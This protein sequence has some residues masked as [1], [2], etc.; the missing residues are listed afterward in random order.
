VGNSGESGDYLTAGSGFAKPQPNLGP[1][2][3]SHLYPR[4]PTGHLCALMRR[5]A[6]SPRR[7]SSSLAARKD[8]FVAM[9]SA[10][11]LIIL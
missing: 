9:P 1:R 4:P 6:S 3:V 5:E 2:T 11:A 8:G 10:R 7:S